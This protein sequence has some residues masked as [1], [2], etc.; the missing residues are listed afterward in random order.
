M[1]RSSKPLAQAVLCGSFISL[2]PTLL[3][4]DCTHGGSHCFESTGFTWKCHPLTVEQREI[5]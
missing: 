3:G 2:R 4:C 5:F 1:H